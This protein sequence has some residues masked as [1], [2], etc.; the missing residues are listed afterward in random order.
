[1][2][3]ETAY[4]MLELTFPSTRDE[5]KKAFHRLAHIHHPDKGGNAEDFKRINGAYQFLIQR[6]YWDALASEQ[7]ASQQTERTASKGQPNGWEKGGFMYDEST[8]RYCVLDDDG[9]VMRS[10]SKDPD[11]STIDALSWRD[12]DYSIDFKDYNGHLT[13]GD[14]RLS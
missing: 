9:N 3:I 5:V 6:G 2:R 12:L 7:T 1:M 4:A 10:W 11:E 8:H 13:G 14:K